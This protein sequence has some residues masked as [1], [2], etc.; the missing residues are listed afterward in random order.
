MATDP[1]LE[2]V[3]MASAKEKEIVAVRLFG[4]RARGDHHAKSDYDLAVDAPRW[5][6]AEWS[7]WSENLREGV[8]TL[9]GLDLVWVNN[10]TSSDLLQAIERDGVFLFQR[11]KS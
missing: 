9:A 5:S 3:R 6:R 7:R 2:F 11:G 8:P 1:I 4:S 10:D